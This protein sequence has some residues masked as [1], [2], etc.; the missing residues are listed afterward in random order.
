M[1]REALDTLL[2]QATDEQRTKFI[3]TLRDS[4]GKDDMKR[5]DLMTLLGL[6]VP[7][8]LLE[9]DERERVHAV[10]AVPARVDAQTVDHL[11][12]A[13]HAAM[14][15]DDALGAAALMPTAQAQLQLVESLMLDCRA[16]LR[17]SLMALYAGHT[18]FMG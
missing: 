17:P 4:G 8:A 18:A 11:R 7:V 6:G 3:E 16:D 9:S 15:Q 13:L 1:S 12:A 14:R 10:A 2:R 5:R